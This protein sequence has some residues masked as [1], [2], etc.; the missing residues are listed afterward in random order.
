MAKRYPNN[1]SIQMSFLFIEAR[2]Q[3]TGPYY[4]AQKKRVRIDRCFSS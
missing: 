1:K 3:I 2:E 4:R